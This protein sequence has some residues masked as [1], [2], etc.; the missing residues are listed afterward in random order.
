MQSE[1]LV[2]P[3]LRTAH[4]AQRTNQNRNQLHAL[5]ALKLLKLLKLF[6]SQQQR[7]PPTTIPNHHAETKGRDVTHHRRRWHGRK[8]HAKEE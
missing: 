4:S 5:H 6:N 1:S 2:A 3:A 7:S 8:Y